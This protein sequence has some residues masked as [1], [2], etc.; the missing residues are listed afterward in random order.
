M[1]DAIPISIFRGNLGTNHVVLGIIGVDLDLVGVYSDLGILSVD[2]V[3]V[4][5]ACSDCGS[6]LNSNVLCSFKF[7]IKI[8]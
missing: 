1:L 8:A 3:G 7:K 2:L 6:Y 4:R 5:I